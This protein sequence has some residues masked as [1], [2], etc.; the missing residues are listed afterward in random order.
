M[1]P[2]RQARPRRGAAVGR[3]AGL[4]SA[5]VVAAL[6]GGVGAGAAAT[7]GDARCDEL[8][9]VEGGGDVAGATAVAEAL[10]ADLRV[11]PRA[12]VT[13]GRAEAAGGIDGL[14]D[15]FL[16][17]CPSWQAGDGGARQDLLLLLVDADERVIGTWLGD[18]LVGDVDPFVTTAHDAMREDLV[19]GRWGPAL[20]AG[21]LAYAGRLGV[22]PDPAPAWV[23]PA[24][25]GGG[26]VVAG[27]AGVA[28]VAGRRRRRRRDVQGLAEQARTRTMSTWFDL[29]SRWEGIHAGVMVMVEAVHEDD[30]VAATVEQEA[31]EAERALGE[32]REE[33]LAGP[34]PATVADQAGADAAAEAWARL[35]GR[36]AD[37]AEEVEEVDAALARLTAAKAEAPQRV[38]DADAAVAEADAAVAAARETRL[39]DSA[40]THVA[41]RAHGL[42]DDARRAADGARAALEAGRFGDAVVAAEAAVARATEAR[43]RCAELPRLAA[44]V[45]DRATAARIAAREAVT[46]A[47][48]SRN[49]LTT[50]RSRFR[51]TVWDDISDAPDRAVDLAEEAAA[52][53]E[54]AADAAHEREQDWDGAL[55]L[56]DRADA[57]LAESASL[58]AAPRARDAEASAAL[59]DAR[60]RVA[61]VRWQAT[62]AGD[63]L[64]SATTD[65]AA[66]RKA[67]DAAVRQVHRA[68]ELL[69]GKPDP[70][71]AATIA[72]EAAAALEQA[73]ASAQRAIAEHDRALDHA[74]GVVSRARAELDRADR[75]RPRGR[76]WADDLRRAEALLDDAEAELR[77][78]PAAAADHAQRALDAARRIVRDKRRA[79]DGDRDQWRATRRRAPSAGDVLGDVL[80]GVL[81][82]GRAGGA[83]RPP[84]P[85]GSSGTVLGGSPTRRAPSS[86]GGSTG[87]RSSRTGSA[88]RGRGGG[89]FGGGKS[90]RF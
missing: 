26:L 19:A 61:K 58:A 36:V 64:A 29:E 74:R 14:A 89:R 41:A 11:F 86:S 79:R 63:L 78:D 16:D 68:E 17:A 59:E 35:E 37:V 44:E 62:Q 4:A 65:V 80:G 51:R 83:V 87:R 25:L 1:R 70:V 18:D 2:R 39:P 48:S 60:E 52:L 32:V 67:I 7:V 75:E 85:R 33:L 88:S 53:A 24:A 6:V 22:D 46:V 9:V 84:R 77:D 40:A 57:L 38:A 31:D 71:R 76:R 15:A 49:A 69:Q 56:L 73:T 72:G 10:D 8:V 27:G 43:E 5:G 21:L 47:T 23:V 81:T 45:P 12:R 13:R 82:G 66:Q 54:Q 90:S 55:A 28:V 30:G 50:L 42:V 3:L 20:E 34:D